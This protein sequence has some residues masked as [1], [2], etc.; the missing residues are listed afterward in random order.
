MQILHSFSRV[1][2]LLN[3]QFTFIVNLYHE[4]IAVDEPKEA[5]QT[6]KEEGLWI[7]IFSSELRENESHNYNDEPVDS[8][9]TTH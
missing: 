7:A 9:Y 6:L 5:N 4:A 3:L 1:E 8:H 2:F